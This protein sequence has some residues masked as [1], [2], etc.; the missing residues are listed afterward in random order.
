MHRQRPL[1]LRRLRGQSMNHSLIKE[2]L[3]I[4]LD[5]ARANLAEKNELYGGY[6]R[7]GLGR[8]V[9]HAER[10]VIFIEAALAD[11]AKAEGQS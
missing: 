5:Y 3:E 11:L 2:A 9:A 8:N 6:P 7:D 1:R 10:E 4:G